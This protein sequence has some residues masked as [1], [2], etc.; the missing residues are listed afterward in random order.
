MPESHKA[1]R[2]RVQKANRAAG[3]GD[4]MGRLA[5]RVKVEKKLLL[6]TICSQEMTVTKSNTDLIRHAENKHGKTLEI[7]FPA[8]TELANEMISKAAAKGGGGGK[9]S[10]ENKNPSL[11]KAQKKKKANLDMDDLLSAGIPGKK[12]KKGK[13]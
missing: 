4:E 13:K 2:R 12:E 9:S 11:S 3:I 5:G 8:A 10:G 7:C 1:E 6:C